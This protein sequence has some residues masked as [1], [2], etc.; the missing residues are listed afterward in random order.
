MSKSDFT[1]DYA[2]PKDYPKAAAAVEKPAEPTK[3]APA[4]PVPVIK[5]GDRV[6]YGTRGGKVVSSDVEAKTA[7]VSFE[8]PASLETLLWSDLK[9]MSSG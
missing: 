2:Y 3:E 1:D 4:G 5:T 7:V 8:S 9:R 6:D